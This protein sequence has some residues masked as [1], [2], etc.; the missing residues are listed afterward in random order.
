MQPPNV[1]DLLARTRDG[2]YVER[3]HV[4]QACEAAVSMAP[5]SSRAHFF[6]GLDLLNRGVLADAKERFLVAKVL[7]NSVAERSKALF[8][9]GCMYEEEGA[10]REALHKYKLAADEDPNHSLPAFRLGVL[11][12]R[13]GFFLEASFW[14]E[15]ALE[16]NDK[17]IFGEVRLHLSSCYA[18]SCS[19]PNAALRESGLSLSELPRAEAL[20]ALNEWVAALD[21][22]N[23]CS[24]ESLDDVQIW[25]GIGVCQLRLG[26]GELAYASFRMC[27]ELQPQTTSHITNMLVA[28]ELRGNFGKMMAEEYAALLAEYKKSGAFSAPVQGATKRRRGVPPV[29]WFVGK[30]KPVTETTG[31]KVKFSVECAV[32]FCNLACSAIGFGALQ[33]ARILLNASLESDPDCFEALF[34][35]GTLD[36]ALGNNDDALALLERAVLLWP[37]NFGA[38]MNY[39]VALTRVG[40]FGRAVDVLNDARALDPNNS[41]AKVNLGRALLSERK[42]ASKAVALFR[43]ALQESDE[44]TYAIACLAEGLLMLGEDEEAV[45]KASFCVD[46][47]PKNAKYLFLYGLTLM[48]RNVKAAIESLSNCVLLDPYHL[49]AMLAL[50]SL[51]RAQNEWGEAREWYRRSLVCDANCAEAHFGMGLALARLEIAH[52]AVQEFAQCVQLNALHVDAYIEWSQVLMMNGQIDGALRC[53][54]HAQTARVVSQQKKIVILMKQGEAYASLGQKESARAC[55]R[56]VLSLDETAIDAMLKLELL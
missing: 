17:S 12:M 54:K 34:N 37:G 47:E 33:Q 42:E 19:K 52:L 35:L 26:Q 50:G 45:L 7:A 6:L 25:S 14:L 27:M 21:A 16:G 49:N 48:K 15:R 39:G 2:F 51:C 32:V 11:K 23:L 53:L 8:A 3:D 44:S 36:L 40:R 24:V 31:R 28:A 22:F 41:D 30:D 1:A 20:L 18:R 10:V 38:L 43:E 55:F 5:A 4:T 56:E 46:R 29:P 13:E 9:L